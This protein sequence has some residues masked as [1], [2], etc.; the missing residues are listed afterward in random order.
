VCVIEG[1]HRADTLL[2]SVL[3]GLP[4]TLSPALSG[5]FLSDM[6]MERVPGTPGASHVFFRRSP[7][8]KNNF[9]GTKRRAPESPAF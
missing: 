4:K 6:P 5:A 9:G 2:L 7:S 8:N 3:D 1:P